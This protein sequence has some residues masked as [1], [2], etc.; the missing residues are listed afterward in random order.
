MDKSIQKVLRS[1]ADGLKILPELLSLDDLFLLFGDRRSIAEKIADGSM[2]EPCFKKGEI[3]SDI[4]ERIKR[5]EPLPYE[6]QELPF[7]FN[8]DEC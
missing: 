1:V 5:R 6:E 4:N 8:D 7:L 3:L 2:V